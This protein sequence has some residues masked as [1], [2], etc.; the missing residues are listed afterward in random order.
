MSFIRNQAL[1]A[2]Q[3]IDNEI[4]IAANDLLERMIKGQTPNCSHLIIDALERP[5]GISVLNKLLT[6]TIQRDNE[7]RELL[8]SK[9]AL[10]RKYKWIDHS[11]VAKELMREIAILEPERYL[12]ASIRCTVEGYLPKEINVPK[13]A[14]K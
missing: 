11:D 1:V 7:N 4:D 3:E 2:Q 12:L 6:L 5:N 14:V 10:L 13:H 9:Y 8:V